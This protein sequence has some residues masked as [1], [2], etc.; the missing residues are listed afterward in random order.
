[1]KETEK[2]PGN[3]LQR[4][5]TIGKDDVINRPSRRLISG[6]AYN[7]QKC[8]LI[9]DTPDAAGNASYICKIADVSDAGYGV[10]CRAAADTPEHFQLG[11]KMTLEA[12]DGKQSRVEICWVKN[13]R[14]GLKR[15]AGKAG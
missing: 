10:V 13:V 8:R 4:I 11:T 5:V 7:A 15:A 3:G 6:V 9:P 2:R 14:L 1:M 12:G